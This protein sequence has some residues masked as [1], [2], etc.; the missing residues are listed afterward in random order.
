[1]LTLVGWPFSKISLVWFGSVLYYIKPSW[2]FNTKSKVYI[3]HFE[4]PWFSLLRPVF[5]VC[6]HICNWKI[7]LSNCAIVFLLYCVPSI[8]KWKPINHSV[9][10]RKLSYLSLIGII[11]RWGFLIWEL[12]F[13]YCGLIKLK[14]S[15]KIR[16][17]PD[18]GRPDKDL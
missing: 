15:T 3:D 10:S 14:T 2:L 9:D 17:G 13:I 8:Y 11:L 7:S 1:M 18:S 16:Y 6:E 5:N 4:K 12:I